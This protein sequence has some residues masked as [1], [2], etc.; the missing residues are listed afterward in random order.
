M[1]RLSNV[2]RSIVRKGDRVAS[3]A[4]NCP[5]I[6]E[7][8]Y[9][10]ASVGAAFVPLNYRAKRDELA[11]MLASCQPRIVFAGER[12]LPLVR[13]AVESLAESP[14]CFRYD[15]YVDA[16]DGYEAFLRGG[17]DFA[18]EATVADDDVS[19]IIY[20]SGTTAQPKGVMLTHLG[21]S[22]YVFNT[23]EPPDPERQEVQLVSVPLYH[24]AGAMAMLSSVFAGRK[25]VILPQFEAGDWL[26]AVESERVTH[27]FVVPTML[28]RIIEHQRFA[29]TDLSSLSLLAYGAAPM[30][31][32]LVTK[33]VDLFA[34]DLVNAYG[35]TESASTLTYLSPEDHRLDGLT[36]EER[37]KMLRRL[38]SVGRP[39]GDVEVAILG[40]DGRL[41]AA[42]QV[43]EVV[44]RGPRVMAGYYGRDAE[45]GSALAGGWLHT[46][47]CGY[48]DED[49]Y[50]YLTGRL[51][52]LIIR[53]GENIAPHEVEKALESHPA[54]AEA[55]V[56]G[57]PSDEWGEEVHAAVVLEAG[58][59]LTAE[60]L[61][62]HCHQRLA[63]YKVPTRIRFVG[64]LPRNAL[65]KVLKAELRDK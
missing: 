48:T 13:E 42:G 61:R 40:G 8:Y 58:S 6:V 55:A 59:N 21:L 31:H 63:S 7:T 9:A 45:T 4:V 19:L 32:A 39:L 43:G 51:S 44:A 3:V 50:V 64:E 27:S 22:S 46:G 47:D 38:G 53:G 37:Q 20:T 54:V 1:N 57:A 36:G 62:Q 41:L 2:L 28:K 23:A 12:Y 15:A 60:E 11:Y 26:S 16:G 30:P 10:C 34:C 14:M 29:D 49:G 17:D 18:P 25:M 56:Y 65:G 52:E 24:I 5:Q 35:Q 33:V